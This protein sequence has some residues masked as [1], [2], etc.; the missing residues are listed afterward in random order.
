MD[1]GTFWQPLKEPYCK[2]ALKMPEARS[3]QNI[4]PSI[5][6]AADSTRL[7]A[8]LTPAN[9][10]SCAQL[11][12]P[13]SVAKVSMM[14]SLILFLNFKKMNTKAFHNPIEFSLPKILNTFQQWGLCLALRALRGLRPAAS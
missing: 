12:G 6:A 1:C 14:M 13:L 9:T 10:P 11:F 2:F 7:N 5:R 4:F 3:T 8:G